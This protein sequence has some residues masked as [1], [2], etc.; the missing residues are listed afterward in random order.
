MG[1][2]DWFA[3]NPNAPAF[4]VTLQNMIITAVLILI[5]IQAIGILF[6]ISSIK[7]G[8]VFQLIL[9]AATVLIAFAIAKKQI[10]GGEISKQ[11][12]FA[13][14]IIVALTIVAMIYMKDYIPVIF[15]RGVNLAQSFLPLPNV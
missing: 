12:F 14:I 9:I 10:Q 11:D 6:N 4:K 1:F 5:L 2:K 8:P 7:L 15:Q 13:L 3:R